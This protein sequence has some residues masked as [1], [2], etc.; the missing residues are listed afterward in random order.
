VPVPSAGTGA[1]RRPARSLN[2]SGPPCASLC[3]GRYE[4]HSEIGSGTSAFVY[5]GTDTHLQRE[6]AIKCFAKATACE[7]AM[8]RFRAEAQLA[9]E[10]DGPFIARFFDTFEDADYI[11]L[12]GEYHP[13]G[14]LA[15]AV[16][17]GG[18]V[19]ESRARAIVAEI[20]TGLEWLHKQHMTIHRDMKLENILLDRDGHVRISDFGFSKARRDHPLVQTAC[21][22]PAYASPEM[23]QRQPYNEKT[24]VW[25][26]GVIMYALL[27][28]C[29]PFNG[30]NVRE[31]FESIICSEPAVDNGVSDACASL[32]REM[33]AKDPAQRPTASQVL[34]HRWITGPWPRRPRRT[35]CPNVRCE[36]EAV[37]RAAGPLPALLADPAARHGAAGSGCVAGEASDRGAAEKPRQPPRPRFVSRLHQRS[38]GPWVARPQ[39]VGQGSRLV[40]RASGRAMAAT[41]DE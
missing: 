1:R 27:H 35:T 30:K 6:I 11:Y 14:D 40:T 25:S 20:A 33:L 24:D 31:C 8:A 12:V 29:L 37:D 28:G 4:L 39:V 7:A 19:G 34:A 23:I 13:G 10:L 17:C 2:M 21:G 15:D 36:K 38:G 26:T 32:L 9:L 16:L 18:T 5:Y 41:R 3:E 22:S